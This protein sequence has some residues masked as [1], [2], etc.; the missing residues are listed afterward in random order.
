[1]K[2]ENSQM[3]QTQMDLGSSFKL[4]N[5]GNIKTQG[6]IGEFFQAI[7]DKF[8]SAETINARNEN[9]M[10]AMG[11]M[12]KGGDAAAPL[13]G[14]KNLAAPPAMDAKERA[15]ALQSAQKAIIQGA[16]SKHI[17]TTYGD[18]TKGVQDAILRHLSTR[19]SSSTS[20]SLPELKQR[21]NMEITRSAQNPAE[22][23]NKLAKC[24]Y[25]PAKSTEDLAPQRAH[26]NN[27]IKQNIAADIGKH[28]DFPN[29]TYDIYTKDADRTLPIFEGVETN[30][31]NHGSTLAQFSKNPVE[32][33]MVAYMCSQ[34]LTFNVYSSA[35][36]ASGPPLSEAHTNPQSPLQFG[37]TNRAPFN[38][39]RDDNGDVLISKQMGSS[40]QGSYDNVL[41]NT[42]N[43]GNVDF[44]IRVPHEQFADFANANDELA[45][46]GTQEEKDAYMTGLLQDFEPQIEISHM[47][48]TPPT[49]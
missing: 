2:I 41:H 27:V 34:T 15:T 7:G 38:I 21:V 43:L 45:K 5:Q 23:T 12:L 48:L 10:V 29:N 22:L 46:L 3:L 19:A 18:Q 11:T 14:P 26:L 4:D 1:M 28:K 35:L 30:R 36:G 40:A 47:T 8:R 13:N 24:A 31:E 49:E 6:K 33:R 39:S 32:Q 16:I 37:L 17:E 20:K 9:L 42:S 44:T 25:L